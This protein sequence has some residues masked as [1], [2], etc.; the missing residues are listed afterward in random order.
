MTGIDNLG[1]D[2]IESTRGRTVSK[3]LLILISNEAIIIR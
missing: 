1:Y 2:D 3:T